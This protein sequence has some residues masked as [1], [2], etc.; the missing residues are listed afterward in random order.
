MLSDNSSLI[1]FRPSKDLFTAKTV[2]FYLLAILLKP[3]PCA[4]MVIDGTSL[5]NIS[6]SISCH[7]VFT[8]N[9]CYFSTLMII[10]AVVLKMTFRFVVYYYVTLHKENNETYYFLSSATF[11]FSQNVSGD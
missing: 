11:H 7:D 3:F 10:G 5:S 1:Y 4:A 6:I 9:Y 8:N 2:A